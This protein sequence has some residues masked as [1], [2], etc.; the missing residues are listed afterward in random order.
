MNELRAGPVGLTRESYRAALESGISML[1]DSNPFVQ[2]FETKD[3]GVDESGELFSHLAEDS[4]LILEMKAKESLMPLI[5]DIQEKRSDLSEEEAQESYASIVGTT[6]DTFASWKGHYWQTLSSLLCAMLFQYEIDE[7]DHEIITST[8]KKIYVTGLKNSSL[9]KCLKLIKK[10]IDTMLSHSKKTN[11]TAKIKEAQ[12]Y[13]SSVGDDDNEGHLKSVRERYEVLVSF[14]N[15]S[16][17]LDSIHV[18]RLTDLARD[19][20]DMDTF[21]PKFSQLCKNVQKISSELDQC[22]K[23]LHKLNSLECASLHKLSASVN[24]VV[25][26]EANTDLSEK[27]ECLDLNEKAASELADGLYSCHAMPIIEASREFARLLLVK[28]IFDSKKT[29][30]DKVYRCFNKVMTSQRQVKG[31]KIPSNTRLKKFSVENLGKHI[32]E[33]IT[34]LFWDKFFSEKALAGFS[35]DVFCL[36]VLQSLPKE[37]LEM[38]R[39]EVGKLDDEIEGV[40]KNYFY[41]KLFKKLQSEITSFQKLK[42][43]ALI[44][45]REQKIAFQ[46]LLAIV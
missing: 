23:L 24:L 12:E 45:E 20:D 25:Q 22:G 4:D 39:D 1:E 36:Q 15:L 28:S 7:E 18:A 16:E 41:E 9:Q 21:Y 8:I 10:N 11:I 46:K 13:I 40:K 27:V 26:R 43:I 34:S 37:S 29:N 35:Y 19:D 17:L 42:S 33:E 2:M 38:M 30:S 6:H 44:S 14:K 3:E 32:D 31:N 5:Y